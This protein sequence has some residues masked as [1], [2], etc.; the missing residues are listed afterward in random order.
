MTWPK[1]SRQISSCVFAGKTRLANPEGAIPQIPMEDVG[2]PRI[3]VANQPGV[4]FRS[5]PEVVDGT[6][7][8]HQRFT[9]KLSQGVR[10]ADFKK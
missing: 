7:I 5:L 8:H 1:T 10:P 9:G 6:V 4:V 3:L 2:N